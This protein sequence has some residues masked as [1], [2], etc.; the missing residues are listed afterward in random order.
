MTNPFKLSAGVWKILS[1]AAF[2][3]LVMDGPLKIRIQER[4][5]SVEGG[6]VEAGKVDGAL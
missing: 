1:F 5:Q 3:V 6:E 2:G 4:Y